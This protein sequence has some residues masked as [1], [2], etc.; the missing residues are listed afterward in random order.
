MYPVDAMGRLADS[1][2]V[3]IA[4]EGLACFCKVLAL[5]W[6]LASGWVSWVLWR[7]FRRLAWLEALFLDFVLSLLLGLGIAGCA[8]GLGGGTRGVDD[9]G[10]RRSRDEA[11]DG[12]VEGRPAAVISGVW[13]GDGSKEL[14]EER[15]SSSSKSEP[16]PSS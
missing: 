5:S 9:V 6:R 11:Y 16:P 15:L 8:V 14:S 7:F 4:F 13:S 10:R 12:K 2:S 3:L 1:K